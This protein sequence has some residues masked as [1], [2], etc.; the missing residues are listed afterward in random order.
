MGISA[1]EVTF[2][3]YLSNLC[4]GDV[5]AKNR[6]RQCFVEL[7]LCDTCTMTDQIREKTFVTRCYP[8]GHL[9]LEDILKVH[10]V[11]LLLHVFYMTHHPNHQ[12]RK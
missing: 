5:L 2:K 11:Q 6:K 7:Q 1:Y 9:I 8:A 3:T 4:T 10:N 12:L